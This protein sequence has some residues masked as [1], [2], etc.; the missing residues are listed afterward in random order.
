MHRGLK[1]VIALTLGFAACSKPGSSPA[2]TPIKPRDFVM[3]GFQNIVLGITPQ[4]KLTL[5]VQPDSA[6]PVEPVTITVSGLPVGINADISPVSDSPGFTATVVFNQ[7]RLLNPGTY[8]VQVTGTSSSY[9]HTN[10]V[11]LTAP[12]FNGFIVNNRLYPTNGIQYGGP[13]GSAS[14]PKGY[15]VWSDDNTTP[16]MRFTTTLIIGTGDPG[17]PSADGTYA[18]PI[19][20]GPTQNAIGAIG[21]QVVIHD[22][23]GQLNWSVEGGTPAIFTKNGYIM[24]LKIDSA[25]VSSDKGGKTTL[26]VNTYQP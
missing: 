14:G 18:Y 17:W 21:G 8:T 22:A 10:S 13:I 15:V 7:T 12:A 20:N 4:N 24:R 2:P 6:G 16:G 1:L 26:I 11:S 23:A 5:S 9:T 19:V 25:S 3:S